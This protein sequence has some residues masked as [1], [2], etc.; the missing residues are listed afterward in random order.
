LG[1]RGGERRGQEAVVGVR[2]KGRGNELQQGKNQRRVGNEKWVLRREDKNKGE[3]EKWGECRKPR[4]KLK[5]PLA[6]KGWFK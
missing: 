6:R 4:K 2:I 3:R 1:W 5:R